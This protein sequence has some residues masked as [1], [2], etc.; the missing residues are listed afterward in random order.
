MVRLHLVRVGLGFELR[1]REVLQLRRQLGEAALQVD[2]LLLVQV[3]GLGLHRPL[4]ILQR[5]ELPDALLLG[6]QRRPQAL[7]LSLGSLQLLHHGGLP[8]PGVVC[9]P[10]RLVE[11]PFLHLE[12]CL[13]GAHLGLHLARR[14]T[15]HAPLGVHALLDLSLPVPHH[16][17]LVA[18]GRCPVLRLP[19][20]SLI[21]LGLGF[22]VRR[23]RRG[24]LERHATG[25]VPLAQG[26]VNEGP[27]GPPHGGGVHRTPREG[28]RRRFHRT[29]SCAAPTDLFSGLFESKGRIFGRNPG[30]WEISVATGYGIL[31]YTLGDEENGMA[32]A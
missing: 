24:R 29:L 28:G 9:L 17:E 5:G 6:L 13:R 3:R 4:L 7:D 23:Q 20:K 12:L 8:V 15:Q 2:D 19:P 14:V 1:G 16:L 22:G 10:P 30:S 31:G 18:Q 26:G 11:L 32:P 21:R 25:S 27:L